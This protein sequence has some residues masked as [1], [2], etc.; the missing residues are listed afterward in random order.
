MKTSTLLSSILAALIS[1]P[2]LGA[3][4]VA[5]KGGGGG[6]TPPANPAIAY[7]G[8]SGSETGKLVV[9]NADGTNATA[10]YSLSQG[11]LDT[12]TWSPDGTQ[13]AF[14]VSGSPS[15]GLWRIDVGVV[16]GKPKGSNATQLVADPGIELA[17]WGAAWSPSGDRIAYYSV[18]NHM[19]TI[20]SAPSSGGTPTVLYTSSLGLNSPTWSPDASRIAFLEHDPVYDSWQIRVLDVATGA[21]TTVLGG[22]FSAQ[23]GYGGGG[24]KGLDWARTADVLAFSVGVPSNGSQAI[25]LLD[26]AGG[27]PVLV[28]GAFGVQPTWSSDDSSILYTDW[29][30]KRLRRVHLAT[31][32]VT[33]IGSK[34][35][36]TPDWRRF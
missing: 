23:F 19:Y 35:G 11:N 36:K 7:I 33:S 28:A 12:P 5:Q 22:E 3:S 15:R 27:S 20:E 13:I 17:G 25:Y 29:A 9:M 31:G 8:T 21:A 32:V 2:F 26:L 24:Y 30:D 1:L 10:I 6:S 34:R 18:T 14:T 4:S 16:S